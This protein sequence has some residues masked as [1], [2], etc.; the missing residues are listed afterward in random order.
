MKYLKKFD[1]SSY[2][3]SDSG[4]HRQDITISPNSLDIIKQLHESED[5]RISNIAEAIIGNF[6]AP[7]SDENL[8]SGVFTKKLVKIGRL[9][10]LLC[11][12]SPTGIE[13][14]FSDKDI[15]DFSKAFSEL[16]SGIS[17]IEIFVSKTDI[18]KF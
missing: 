13:K 2:Y 12:L 11:Y 15:Y 9:L 17:T 4:L 6:Y 18:L 8:S 3:V 5:E 10:K 16:N 14:E 7:P 1:E